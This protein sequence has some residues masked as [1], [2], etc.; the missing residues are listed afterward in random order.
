VLHFRSFVGLELIGD[1][2]FLPFREPVR[3]IVRALDDALSLIMRRENH[4]AF[5]YCVV[6]VTLLSSPCSAAQVIS[7]CEKPGPRPFNL[8]P[9]ASL[10]L[11]L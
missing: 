4:G 7:V 11:S 5:P 8:F 6:D 1:S 9:C 3:K 10:A 2:F